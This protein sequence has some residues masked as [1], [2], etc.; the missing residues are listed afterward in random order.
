MIPE[1]QPGVG[2]GLI[3]LAAG[4]SSRLGEP[5][6]RLLLRGR[7][8]LQRSLDAASA[9]TAHPIIVVLGSGAD[10]LRKDLVGQDVTTVVNKGWREG[11]ASSIRC[12]IGE[13]LVINPDTPGAI[14][15]VCDQ[16]HVA[17]SVLNKLITEHQRTNKAFI[18]CSYGNTIG[19]P[20]LFS[21]T[22]FGELLQLEGDVGAKSLL[23]R[24]RDEVG[25]I[26]FP[27]GSIDID[28]V[29]DYQALSAAHQQ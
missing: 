18:A 23:H 27:E 15:M 7:T 29:V 12:G 19:T 16:P 2:P 4:G 13:L 14:L 17:A 25:V 22:L 20:A 5:K 24:H 26:K 8:L 21:R 6:Q 9:S 11:I 1:N 3:L 10:S 28:T